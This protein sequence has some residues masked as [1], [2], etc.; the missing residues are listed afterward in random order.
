MRDFF[1]LG[2]AL[3]L[4]HAMIAMAAWRR[5]RKGH[6]PARLNLGDCYSYALANTSGGRLLFKGQDFAQ[7]DV[8]SAISA[9]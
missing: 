8:A 1:L 5:F 3:D 7:T 9:G 6:H 2:L 4:N